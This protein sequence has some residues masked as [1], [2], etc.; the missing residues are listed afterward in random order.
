MRGHLAALGFVA[1]CL[2][3]PTAFAQD[4]VHDPYEGLNRDLFAAHEAI[5]NAV[6]EPVAR[7]YRAATP[8]LL[9]TGVSNFL[10]NLRSPV[11]LA[12]DVLQAEP[13][14]AG[15]T[16]VR[17]GIN[18]IVGVLGLF[19]P[20]SGMGLERHDEDFGQ[21][22]AVWGI[23]PGPYFFIPV[24]GPTNLRDSAGRIVD[25]AFDP[26]NWAAFDEADEARQIRGA[27]TGISAREALLDEVDS[28]G[29]NSVDAYVTF[30][31]SYALFRESAI[32]NGPRDV[33]ELPE[34]EEVSEAAPS[35]ETPP[36]GQP[37]LTQ[38]SDVPE[39]NLAS[40]V[41]SGELK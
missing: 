27:L 6:L 4:Q 36:T 5:D 26:L 9:R 25:M 35:L 31:S 32:R 30:R 1:A 23:E 2:C 14:R 24:L 39:Q 22:L 7:G 28:V 8:R 18:S 13:A 17:F 11:I 19:D 41:A 21:T 10:R 38:S 20:A 37:P 12:N 15:V 3:A 16:V 29:E 33:Q 40:F 34:F